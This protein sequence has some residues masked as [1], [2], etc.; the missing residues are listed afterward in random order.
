MG[1]RSENKSIAL[2]LR[3]LT[4]RILGF[5]P[6]CIWCCVN[7][8]DS[9]DL[10]FHLLLWVQFTR[11]IS[12]SLF[13]FSQTHQGHFW[14]TCVRVQPLVGWLV[15]WICARL[16]GS[17]FQSLPR[18]GPLSLTLC[19]SEL[20]HVVLTEARSLQSVE[21]LPLRLADE[22]FALC[23]YICSWPDEVV[24]E[25]TSPTTSSRTLPPT[26]P[27]NT[28]THYR[29]FSLVKRHS[30]I[31][32]PK[33]LFSFSLGCARGATEDAGVNVWKQLQRWVPFSEPGRVGRSDKISNAC[34]RAPSEKSPFLSVASTALVHTLTWA[35]LSIDDITTSRLQMTALRAVRK[36]LICQWFVLR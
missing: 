30:L 35:H 31:V 18:S 26:L 15:R 23:F 21:L 3:L 6:I 1:R 4:R 10:A 32:Q 11:S 36:C 19:C 27:P 14:F 29:Y 25:W 7:R 16:A 20:Q 17:R 34:R 24:S 33:K 22:I 12:D 28:H 13:W 5:C 2:R 9:L 8:F